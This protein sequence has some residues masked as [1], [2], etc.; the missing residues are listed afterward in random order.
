MKSATTIVSSDNDG[1]GFVDIHSSL[2]YHI[3]YPDCFIFPYVPLRRKIASSYIRIMLSSAIFK[4]FFHLE[5]SN[6]V[7]ESFG[8]IRTRA[9]SIWSNNLNMSE[10]PP[11]SNIPP[12]M[13]TNSS[14]VYSTIY[15]LKYDI[16]S[17]SV[18]KYSSTPKDLYW[19][20]INE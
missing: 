15:D 8:T 13:Y 10:F 18:L 1:S 16:I 19:R 6:I 17:L 20:P 3:S 9:C 4:C 11:L 2:S 12:K 14:C 7:N 5:T